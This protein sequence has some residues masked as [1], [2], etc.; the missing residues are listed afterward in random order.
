MPAGALLAAVDCRTGDS[1]V[2]CRPS[3]RLGCL[4][5]AGAAHVSA[6]ELYDETAARAFDIERGG[7]SLRQREA[8]ALASHQAASAAAP[9]WRPR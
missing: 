4:T 9:N 7:D 5:F 8:A 3:V 1:Y 6:I 2:L